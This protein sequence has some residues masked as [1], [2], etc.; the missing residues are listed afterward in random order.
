MNSRSSRVSILSIYKQKNNEI[1]HNKEIEK[2]K[3]L[4]EIKNAQK[5]RDRIFSAC[6]PER[7]NK[8]L[9]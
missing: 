7:A 1:F 5:Q 9:K 2:I 3:E 8:Y 6:G 4:K